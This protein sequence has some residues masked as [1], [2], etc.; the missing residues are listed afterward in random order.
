[1]RNEEVIN[2][3]RKGW[4]GVDDYVKFGKLL[5]ALEERGAINFIYTPRRGQVV[6]VFRRADFEKAKHIAFPQPEERIKVNKNLV[7]V[8]FKV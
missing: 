6:A 7:F 4:I 1:M 2:V 8:F 3:I 5:D